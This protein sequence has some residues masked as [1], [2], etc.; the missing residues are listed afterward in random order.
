M[1]LTKQNDTLTTTSS[2]NAGTILIKHTNGTGTSTIFTAGNSAGA[3]A[4][5]AGT[6]AAELGALNEVVIGSS[7]FEVSMTISETLSNAAGSVT[8]QAGDVLQA[9]YVDTADDAGSTSTFYD[10]STFDLRTGTLSIDKDVYVMGSDMVITVTDPD[11]NLDSTTCES[12]AMSLIEWDSSADSSQLLATST[13]DNTSSYFTSNPSSLEETGCDTGVFQTVTT[14]PVQTIGDGGDP[15]Y[16]E[17]FTLTYRDVGLSGETDVEGDTADIEAYGSISNFGALV[18]LDKALYNWTDTVY[19]TIT[20]PD[21]NNNTAA[22]ETIGTSA[23]PIQVTSRNGKMCTSST[24]SAYAIA[25]ETGP[26]TGVFEMEVAL[27]GYALTTAHN[28]PQATADTSTCSSSSST[29]HDLIMAGQTDGVSVS[30]EYTD[31]VVVVA[32]ASVAFNIAEAS[33]DTSSASAGGSAVL[34]VTD[35]D[36]NTN[37]AIIDT[38]KVAVFSDSDN[39][40]FQLVMNE[41]DEDTGVFEGTIY[42]TSTDS[43]SGSNL[44]VSEGDTVTAEYSD[45]TLPEPYTD[46]DDLT[47]ASTLTIG[48]AF[49]PLERAP[50]ANARVVDAFGSS[51]AEVS[52]GQQVQIA[53]DVSNGQSG[54]QAFAYLVQVQD[55]D[56]VTVSLA[57]ITGSL[58]AGQS[59][60][61]ALSWTPS[62][63]GSYTATVFVWESVDNPTALSPTTSVDIDVV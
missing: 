63:S 32:S 33:F 42:F 15:E 7:D 51:V 37:S 59:M 35:A 53:A 18:E 9:W 40:G 56:G 49:P 4:A 55:G 46:S 28:N 24:G 58:T 44:R 21:H 45:K 43:T 19:V 52:S 3:V 12:Y 47:V 17:T 61:P 34:S 20:A 2:S 26:D 62:A 13:A 36:E 29:G 31:S 39:G 16:G 23:L 27:T 41:T 1:I 30:Y 8:I 25:A 6:N 14:L 22:E 38:F 10:S 48:T 60:S 57:W 54:D 11:L 50:A 5:V